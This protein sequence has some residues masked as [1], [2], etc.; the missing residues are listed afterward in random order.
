[1]TIGVKSFMN[2]SIVAVCRERNVVLESRTRYLPFYKT[3]H[4]CQSGS[5]DA[6]KID[7]N[8]QGQ[9]QSSDTPTYQRVL[10]VCRKL[11]PSFSVLISTLLLGAML[12]KIHGAPYICCSNG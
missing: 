3:R 7:K 4:M 8:N 12:H 10:A 9:L 11:S 1:M 2:L 5:Y 6:T